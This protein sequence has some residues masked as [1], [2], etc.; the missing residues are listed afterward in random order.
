VN[1]LTVTVSVRS[2]PHRLVDK[3]LLIYLVGKDLY[4]LSVGN[5][6][7]KVSDGFLHIMETYKDCLFRQHFSTRIVFLDSTFHCSPQIKI[8]D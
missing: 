7:N 2:G 5:I 8:W 1:V 3:H 6:P 4:Q